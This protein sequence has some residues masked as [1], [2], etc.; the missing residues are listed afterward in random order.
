VNHAHPPRGAI[1][2]IKQYYDLQVMWFR[3]ITGVPPGNSYPIDHSGGGVPGFPENGSAYLLIDPLTS[4]MFSSK[5]EEHF[6]LL[7]VDLAEWSIAEPS[8]VVV[9]F[10]G[11]KAD[12]SV[13]STS[14]A[15][16]GIID[17]MGPLPDFETFHFDSRFR[18][19]VRVEIPSWGYAIDNVTMT[20][21]IPEPAS[22]TLLG[23]GG[24]ALWC[25][26]R[27]RSTD[28]PSVAR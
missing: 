16:D 17:G 4:L 11:I 3:P 21:V 14:F 28:T 7:A 9:S 18:D 6:N 27:R 24:L 25:L 12:G 15:T 10:N 22:G 23:L 5:F 20:F 1:Y 26:R 2:G 13:V 8:P 19:L